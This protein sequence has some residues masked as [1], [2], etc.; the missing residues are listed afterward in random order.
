[1]ARYS[2]LTAGGRYRKGG[3]GVGRIDSSGKYRMGV[4]RIRGRVWYYHIFACRVVG[5]PHF[6]GD[7]NSFACS[8]ECFPRIPDVSPRVI[9]FYPENAIGILT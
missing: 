8:I 5:R 1:M 4:G 3:Q 7:E 6:R 9:F 2:Q